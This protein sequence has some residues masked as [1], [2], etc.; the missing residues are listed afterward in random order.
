MAKYKKRADG[1]YLAQ[2]KIG[3]QDNGKPRYKNIYANSQ[4]ALD[5]KVTEYKSLVNKGIIIDDH[6]MSVGEWADSWLEIYKTNIGYNTKIRYVHI[7]NK[8]IKPYI[9]TVKL[10][11]LKL[12]EVQALI[13]QMAPK[14]SYS[15]MKKVKETL[16]QMYKQAIRNGLVYRNPADG[17]QIPQKPPLERKP[18]AEGDIS[19]LTFFCRTYRYGAFIMTLLY[20]G[21]RRGEI[22][23]LTWDDIDFEKNTITI[24]KAVEFRNNQP[25]IKPPKTK[26]GNR[27]IPLLSALRPY[28]LDLKANA[29]SNTVFVNAHNLPHT[30]TSIK[31]LW[32]NFLKEYNRF[33]DN[34]TV[35]VKF[36]MHQFRHT[37]ATLLY[38]AG[39]DVKTAQEF[40][41]HSSINITLDIY[42]HLEEKTREKGARKLD[43]FI[44][45]N[46]A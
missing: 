10:G 44:S 5:K 33:L 4:T 37:Y 14:Y 23:A 42:T 29:A 15:S 31:K 32:D 11:K 7:I 39:V 16:N 34:N 3:Y 6:N 28:L 9:G 18:L 25:F 26:K 43:D 46:L 22:A 17:V 8:Q 13:N 30:D 35:K 24:N 19:K 27:I 12:A 40:L 41:G 38:N 2:V 45:S 36:T 21:L 1:R 20:T